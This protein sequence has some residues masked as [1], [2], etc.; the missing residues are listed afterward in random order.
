MSNLRTLKFYATPEH[1]CSYLP[2]RQARTLFVDPRATI[3]NHLYSQL[4][5]LGFRRSGS[6]IY[7]PHCEDCQACISVRIPAARFRPSKTQH[8]IENRNTDLI[9]CPAPCA[10]TAEY[11]SLYERY[12]RKRHAD[13][14]MYPPSEEQFVSFLTD[15]RTDSC[16][17][18]FR[19]PE[20]T[21]LAVAVSDRLE[22]GLSALYTFY[23]PDEPRRSLGVY[24]IIW[25]IR[26][27][28]RLQLPYLYLG[29]WVEECRKMNYKTAYS[30]L[31]MLLNHKWQSV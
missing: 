27:A 14:D 6:H 31:E 16:F 8:R 7:R 5:N 2:D 20:G 25:Q 18:E 13:G 19:S 12:I 11:Y 24:A 22:Q 23:D 4:S 28:Q 10:F 30:P 3:D 29:Y 17:Y 9:V 26:Q 15:G 21:L 1:D